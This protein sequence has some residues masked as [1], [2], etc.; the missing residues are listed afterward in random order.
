VVKQHY[1]NTKRG[2]FPHRGLLVHSGLARRC[3]GAGY[4]PASHLPGE[5]IYAFYFAPQLLMHDSDARL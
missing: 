4:R 3:R 5:T 2:L 1:R